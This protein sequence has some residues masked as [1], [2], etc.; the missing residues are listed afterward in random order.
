MNAAVYS[1]IHGKLCYVLFVFNVRYIHYITL[2]HVSTFYIRLEILYIFINSPL[3]A[4]LYALSATYL[5][6]SRLV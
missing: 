6:N 2:F 5:L 3:V 4:P 1:S